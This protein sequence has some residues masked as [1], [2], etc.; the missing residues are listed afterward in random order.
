MR[1][2][3]FVGLL[4]FLVSC[5]VKP[6]QDSLIISKD[7]KSVKEICD[8]I[9]KGDDFEK[10]KKDF[11]EPKLVLEKSDFSNYHYGDI[12]EI[13]NLVIEKGKVLEKTYIKA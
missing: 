11:G 3:F 4:I 10:V 6:N 8:G 13:C 12:N 2:I 7:Q 1:K 5:G 9:N